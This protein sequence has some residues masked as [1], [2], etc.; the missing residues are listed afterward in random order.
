MRKAGCCAW[1]SPEKAGEAARAL[2]AEVA[3]FVITALAACRGTPSS[4]HEMPIPLRRFLTFVVS[5]SAVKWNSTTGQ[6]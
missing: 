5:G 2:V 4:F 6:L 1:T 3:V